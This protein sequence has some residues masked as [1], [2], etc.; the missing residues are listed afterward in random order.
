MTS[1]TSQLGLKFCIVAEDGLLLPPPP[2]CWDYRC[3]PTHL[4]VLLILLPEST[5]WFILNMEVFLKL[6]LDQNTHLVKTHQWIPATLRIISELCVQ[7][8]KALEYLWDSVLCFLPPTFPLQWLHPVLGYTTPTPITRPEIGLQGLMP[9][10]QTSLA[11]NYILHGRIP[12]ASICLNCICLHVA[13]S[14]VSTILSLAIYIFLRSVPATPWE[15]LLC[16]LW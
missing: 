12:M 6:K 11:L 4:A 13:F 2:K 3:M 8:C 16:P 15:F 7:I 10:R 5:L 9:A 1:H 14:A